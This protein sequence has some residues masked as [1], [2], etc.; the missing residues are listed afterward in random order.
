MDSPFYTFEVKE[1]ACRFIFNSVGP[2]GEISKIIIYSK[3]DLPNY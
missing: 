2:N 3:T 1:D